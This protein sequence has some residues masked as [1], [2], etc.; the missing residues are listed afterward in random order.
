M[1]AIEEPSTYIDT[2]KILWGFLTNTVVHRLG[3]LYLGHSEAILKHRISD[4][5]EDALESKRR[6]QDYLFEY[7]GALKVKPQ[8][9]GSHSSPPQVT[10]DILLQKI[11]YFAHYVSSRSCNY[12]MAIYVHY[13]MNVVRDVVSAPK[14]LLP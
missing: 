6:T 1:I 9:N 2:A 8:Q 14:G 13:M 10:L 5:T 12:Y 7:S 11:C 4:Y 3:F